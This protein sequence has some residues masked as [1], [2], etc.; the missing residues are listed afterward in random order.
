[1]NKKVKKKRTKQDERIKMIEEE[2]VRRGKWET[3]TRVFL[4]LV[5]LCMQF[6]ERRNFEDS[7]LRY[8]VYARNAAR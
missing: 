8:D 6:N 4:V 1:M 5:F 3:N 7:G 2:G